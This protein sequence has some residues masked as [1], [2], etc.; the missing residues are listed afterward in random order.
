MEIKE[1]T[2][3]K[4]RFTCEINLS[5]ANAIRRS[6][7]EV[8]IISIQEC[9]IYK[10][11]SALYDEVIS[12]RLGLIP[13]KNQKLKQG[14]TIDL[15]LKS[16]GKEGGIEVISEELGDLS[17]YPDMPIVFLDKDQEIEIVARAGIGKSSEH[18]KYCPGLMFYRHLPKI[19]ISKEGESHKE[20]AELY[21]DAFSFENKLKVKDASKCDLD[22]DDLKD[23]P[24][25]EITHDDNSLVF[26]IESW[27]QIS[28]KEIFIESCNALKSE[29]SALS[30][31]LK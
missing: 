22:N 17:V 3:E 2:Q 30:K 20:L 5:L 9:D 25:V 19:K 12:H 18:S 10:N 4:L 27:G 28:P 1:K 31:A 26:Q 21:P 13:L 8:P 23:Y 11:D 16:K 29:L 14:E 7:S 6:I 24:G 15:K